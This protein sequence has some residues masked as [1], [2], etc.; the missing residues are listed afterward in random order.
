[1][2]FG[3]PGPGL[4]LT[5]PD[6][7]R[8]RVQHAQ[9]LADALRGWGRE[10][11]GLVALAT[12]DGRALQAGGDMARGFQLRWLDGEAPPLRSERATLS[13]AEVL[14]RLQA[15]LAAPDDA[16]PRA[17]WRRGRRWCSEADLA[18]RRSRSPWAYWRRWALLLL[19][20]QVVPAVFTGI[21]LWEQGRTDRFLDGAVRH[22]AR[23]VSNQPDAAGSSRRRVT[24]RLVDGPGTY[25][26]VVRKGNVAR[27][28]P[29]D[30]DAVWVARDGRW[31]AE[32]LLCFYCG[33]GIAGAG[34]LFHGLTLMALGF[35]AWQDRFRPPAP[36]RFA[37]L[38]NGP[39]PSETMPA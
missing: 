3:A 8:L 28:Q 30:A 33:N 23:V 31:K 7:S 25:E 18:A 10:P 17:A 9:A 16:G 6:G 27:A 21:G 12:D 20:L 24:L 14:R 29:G 13:R 1:M 32:S 2:S 22:E 15:L 5:L 39:Q 26:L 35:T 38:Q 4:T 34:L 11:G 36:D 19:A 37:A